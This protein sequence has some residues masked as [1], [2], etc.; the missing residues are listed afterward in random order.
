MANV[1]PKTIMKS[2]DT[3]CNAADGPVLNMSRFRKWSLKNHPDKCT[4]AQREE[5]Q[6]RF[7]E[8]KNAMDIIKK[9]YENNEIPGNLCNSTQIVQRP[10]SAKSSS[11]P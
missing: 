11:K 2:I 10:K 3:L 9:L 1:S 4:P 6:E 5:C 8:M 7:V